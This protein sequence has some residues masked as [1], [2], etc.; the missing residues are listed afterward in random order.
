M[1]S[2]KRFCTLVMVAAIPALAACTQT[3][4]VPGM[5][6]T[7]GG[8]GPM[9]GGVT[10]MDPLGPFAPSAGVQALGIAATMTGSGPLAAGAMMAHK[11]EV[12]ARV[13]ILRQQ[14]YPGLVDPKALI[15]QAESA[16]QRAIQSGMLNPDGTVREQEP[17]DFSEE[18]AEAPA[19]KAKPPRKPQS[20]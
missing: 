12:D 14:G 19:Q 9:G 13:A 4:G 6:G 15:A 3:A 8:F 2:C 5:V 17:S 18:L 1:S 16:K 11:A 7:P 20:R 10:G